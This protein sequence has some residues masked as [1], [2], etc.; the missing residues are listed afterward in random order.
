[1][2]IRKPKL[3]YE[4]FITAIDKIIASFS[5][6]ITASRISQNL[7]LLM[8]IAQNNRKTSKNYNHQWKVSAASVE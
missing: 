7:L 1:L 8:Q 3:A 5:A 4:L 2:Q 6:K